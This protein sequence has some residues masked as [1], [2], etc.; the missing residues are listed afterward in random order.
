MA[1]YISKK[2]VKLI[3]A[4]VWLPGVN[5]AE[6]EKIV[7]FGKK[8]GAKIGIQN[9]LRYKFGK[10]PAKQV[11]MKRFYSL[12][13]ELEKKQGVKLVLSATDFLISPDKSLGKPLKKGMVVEA[14]IACDGRLPKEKI[15]AAKGR[16]ISVFDCDK[17]GRVKIRV[18]RTKHNI[19]T[20]KCL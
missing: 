14:E 6:I 15:A 9:F 17:K 16:T 11:P 19:Y 1:E 7:V 13:G 3:I 18:M 10:N 12:L 2:P 5:D 20:G 4:P 8:L